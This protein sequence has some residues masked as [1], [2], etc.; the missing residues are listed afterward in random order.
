MF[1]TRDMFST[2][3]DGLP[4][5]P[6]ILLNIFQ[7]AT[8]AVKSKILMS[9]EQVHKF[10]RSRFALTLSLK[11]GTKATPF[12]SKLG[13]G[14]TLTTTNEAEDVEEASIGA[15]FR[16][17]RMHCN[18]IGR[19]ECHENTDDLRSIFPLLTHL[20]I[21]RLE[22]QAIDTDLVH[23]IFR[24][25]HLTHIRLISCVFTIKAFV[26]FCTFL[27][28]A[29][30]NVSDDHHGVSSIKFID[31]LFSDDNNHS[32]VNVEIC[33]SA[34]EETMVRLK[35]CVVQGPV[36]NIYQS[37][38]RHGRVELNIQVQP[39]IKLNI[40]KTKSKESVLPEQQTEL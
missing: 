3:M 38:P 14:L 15:K 34:S 24:Q 23:H 25:P 40:Q 4:L 35:D 17:Q 29:F 20:E 11:P 36:L 1:T 19:L 10:I 26:D 16:K 8:P 6:D 21:V 28:R 27:S 18:W 7:H 33:G 30:L 22:G 37:I 39:D 2:R 5:H 9:S 32:K 31:V 13:Q 12:S